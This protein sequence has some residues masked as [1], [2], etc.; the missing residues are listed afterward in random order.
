[1]PR[2][3]PKHESTNTALLTPNSQN[4]CSHATLTV[5]IDH[6]V[7]VESFFPAAGAL[8]PTLFSADDAYPTQDLQDCPGLQGA[9]GV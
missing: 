2:L 3:A 1:M 6:T 8:Y 4:M 7:A 9:T 5:A